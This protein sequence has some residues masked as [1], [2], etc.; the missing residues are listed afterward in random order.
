M[1]QV[2][3]ETVYADINVGDTIDGRAV[4]ERIDLV[5]DYGPLVKLKVESHRNVR[6]EWVAM[7]YGEQYADKTYGEAVADAQ[8]WHTSLAY[9]D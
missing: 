8:R 9:G 7:W 6:D 3:S 4:V 2:T 1:A 5:S